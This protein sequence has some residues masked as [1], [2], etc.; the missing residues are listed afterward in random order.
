MGRLPLAKNRFR[1]HGDTHYFLA[2][3]LTHASEAPY[4][5]PGYRG[6]TLRYCPRPP[7]VSAAERNGDA[8]GTATS[9]AF[10]DVKVEAGYTIY[11]VGDSIFFND[12][13]N[14]D[15]VCTSACQPRYRTQRGA[16]PPHAPRPCAS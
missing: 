6:P 13:R 3:E 1:A 9:S 2:T 4:R 16:H 7:H 10:R 12:I 15:Q 11:N 14:L 5:S 8:S